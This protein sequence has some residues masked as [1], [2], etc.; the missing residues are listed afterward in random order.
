MYVHMH[1]RGYMCI[2]I[3]HKYKNNNIFFEDTKEYEVKEISM[4]KENMVRK[5]KW[6][7]KIILWW[8][9]LAHV[10]GSVCMCLCWCGG[11]CVYRC[12]CACVRVCVCVCRSVC[13]F[14][15]V[16]VCMSVHVSVGTCVCGSVCMCACVGV[17][18]G[19]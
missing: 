6:I 5:K 4:Q 8:C 10:C 7:S 13:M 14:V 15:R 16:G 17:C 2:N 11:A 3:H 18:V 1:M 9:V 12:V 19:V